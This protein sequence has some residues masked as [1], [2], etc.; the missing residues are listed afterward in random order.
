M[1]TLFTYLTLALFFGACQTASEKEVGLNTPIRHDDFLYSAR[2]VVVQDSIDKLKASGRFWIVTFRVD[3]QAKRVEHQWANTTAYVVENGKT[4]ENQPQAQ[5]RLNQLQLFGW[6]EQ[7]IT[8]AG[9]TDSTRLV[10]DLP[11]SVT[12]PYLKMR[13]D[14]LMGDVFDGQQ[15]EHTSVRLF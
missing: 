12:K 14:L 9:R 4:F 7:Y 8:L 10:F 5:Q 13:G 11:L 6:K 3:N 1:K 2:R 15:V